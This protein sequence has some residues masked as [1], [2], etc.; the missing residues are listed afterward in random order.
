MDC[1]FINLGTQGVAAEDGPWLDGRQHRV[2]W[3]IACS[4]MVVDRYQTLAIPD[5][6][7]G[8][9][10]VDIEGP[11]SHPGERATGNVLSEFRRATVAT[12]QCH[13][14]PLLLAKCPVQQSH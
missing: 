7:G 2:C 12:A 1:I 3:I 14:S 10:V 13:L 5:T 11:L 6:S 9:W 8:A 4:R